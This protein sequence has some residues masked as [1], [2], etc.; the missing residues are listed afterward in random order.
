MASA[1]PSEFLNGRTHVSTV[2]RVRRRGRNASRGY[3]ER[4]SVHAGDAVAALLV[5][6]V[7]FIQTHPIDEPVLA[8]LRSKNVGSWFSEPPIRG[9]S[10]QW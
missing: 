6:A 4:N 1:R 8:D 5:P 9:R 7:D 3:H 10:G 2:S